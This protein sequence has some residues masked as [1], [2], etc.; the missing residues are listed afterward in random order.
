MDFI[1]FGMQ[2][3]FKPKTDSKGA[4][5]PM[6]GQSRRASTSSSA[7]YYAN[8]TRSLKSLVRPQNFAQKLMG[9]SHKRMDPKEMRRFSSI[10][11]SITAQVLNRE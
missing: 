1:K 4:K 10:Q 5:A 8:R 9:N 3:I 6:G 11:S 7:R 2:R